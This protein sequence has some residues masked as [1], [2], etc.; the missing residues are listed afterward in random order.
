MYLHG[1]NHNLE[2]FFTFDL[3]LV[4]QTH[5]TTNTTTM[6]ITSAQTTAFFTEPGNMDI[7]A[8]TYVAITQERLEELDD[9]VEFYEKSIKQITDNLR[10]PGGRVPD[11]EPNAAAG[12]TIPTSDF[13]F[14]AKSQVCL[15]AAFKIY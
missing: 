5:T 6:V 9:L 14:G 12:A 4:Y 3:R 11:L 2:T 8:S 7:P 15:K 10:R 13:I 1:D